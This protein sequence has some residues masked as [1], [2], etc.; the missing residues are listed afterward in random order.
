M[1][2]DRFGK[3]VRRWGSALVALLKRAWPI[4]LLVGTLAALYT[5]LPFFGPFRQSLFDK[6]SG[7]PKLK[8][9]RWSSVVLPPRRPWTRPAKESWTRQVTGKPV[10]ELS[11]AVRRT[12]AAPR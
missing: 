8:F 11:D 6:V 1:C 10:A 4:W 12:S 3:G 2:R 7:D 5:W 9:D